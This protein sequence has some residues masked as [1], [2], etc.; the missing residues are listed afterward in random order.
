MQRGTQFYHS[1]WA[2]RWK[3]KGLC[4]QAGTQKIMQKLCNI[5]QKWC[6][7]FRSPAFYQPFCIWG[8][9]QIPWR[10]KLLRPDPDRHSGR[11]RVLFTGEKSKLVKKQEGS[12]KKIT[13][14]ATG[15]ENRPGLEWHPILTN[16]VEY[17]ACHNFSSP[18]SSPTTPYFTQSCSTFNNLN[19]QQNWVASSWS[20]GQRL[21]F[22]QRIFPANVWR[23]WRSKFSAIPWASVKK[24]VGWR[25]SWVDVEIVAVVVLYGFF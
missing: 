12:Q 9:F 6:E 22:L 10:P 7:I 5:V 11:R 4:D 24:R 3:K 17:S 14:T 1:R 16:P 19:L 25:G 8:Y 13:A 20:W 18:F 2:L 21:L 23:Y 15:I